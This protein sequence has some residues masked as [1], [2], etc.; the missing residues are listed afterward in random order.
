MIH[1]NSVVS[2]CI[3][4]LQNSQESFNSRLNCQCA[5]D[6]NTDHKTEKSAKT[7]ADQ[8][9]CQKVKE[10]TASDSCNLSIESLGAVIV[11]FKPA[12]D[13]VNCSVPTYNRYDP[14]LHNESSSVSKPKTNEVTLKEPNTNYANF[15]G[16][17]SLQPQTQHL[18]IGSSMTKVIK[19]PKGPKAHLYTN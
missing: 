9:V 11:S 3:A 13:M 6:T 14:I 4:S 19:G 1:K 10:N 18:I 7:A 15:H 16:A 5:P 12:Q 8:D 2:D 17:R